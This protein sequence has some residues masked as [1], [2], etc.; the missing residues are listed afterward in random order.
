MS[1]PYAQYS[2]YIKKITGNLSE[3]DFEKQIVPASF[4]LR[5]MTMNKSDGI[6]TDAQELSLQYAACYIAEMRAAAIAEVTDDSGNVHGGIKTSESN[7]GY[8]VSWASGIQNGETLEE[9]MERR[10]AQIARQY[11]AGTGLLS[12]KERCRCDYECKYDS[13]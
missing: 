10:S 9:N 6:L 3:S 4:F 11:L 1:F 8:S 7:D 5:R 2:F 12:R 13:L